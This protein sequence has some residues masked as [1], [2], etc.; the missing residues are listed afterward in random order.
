MVIL[1]FSKFLIALFASEVVRATGS[2]LLSI[3]GGDTARL[4][5]TTH[6]DA[7]C[8]AVQHGISAALA[9]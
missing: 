9:L 3:A 8:A 4:V 6:S 7:A 2:L 1:E 5:Q